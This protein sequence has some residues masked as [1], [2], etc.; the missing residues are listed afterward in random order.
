MTT[1]RPYRKALALDVAIGELRVNSGTQFAPDVVEA[2]IVVVTRDAPAW[3]LAL[4]ETPSGVEAQ[5]QPVKQA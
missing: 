2:L 4:A 3:E 1:D 5:S